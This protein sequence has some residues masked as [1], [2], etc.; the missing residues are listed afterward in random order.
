MIS[1]AQEMDSEWRAHMAQNA[2]QLIETVK[3]A[4]VIPVI[5]MDDVD[6]ARPAAEALVAG[7]L[8]VLEVTL[9]T[10]N[11]LKVIEEMAKVDGAVLG[12]HDAKGLMQE[13]RAMLKP[14]KGQIRLNVALQAAGKRCQ[15]LLPGRYDTGPQSRGR[16]GT[17]P[18]V[19]A[20]DEF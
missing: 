1:P 6:Q 3:Q 2:E 17:I 12:R 20:I 11:A 4:R 5:I 9:R 7:G 8:N 14:G 18:G 13:L 16:L 15:V 19:L 10:P